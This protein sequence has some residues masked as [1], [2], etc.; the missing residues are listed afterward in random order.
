MEIRYIEL[1]T[2][3]SDNGPAW[4]GS[5]KES[6][7]GKTIYFNDHAFQRHHSEY[8]NYVDVETGEEYW[9]SCVKKNGQDRHWA[10]SGKITIDRKVINEYLHIIQADKLDNS[11]FIV[12]DIEDEFPVERINSIKNGS[13]E[14]KE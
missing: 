7:S 12:A 5:V 4:I 14:S 1:K 6:K 10:G 2:G 11:R 8:S 3:Y 13:G 9:I